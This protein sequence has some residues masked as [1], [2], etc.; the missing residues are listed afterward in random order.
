MFLLSFA[1]DSLEET[2]RDIRDRGGQ[3]LS[4][5]ARKVLEDWVVIDLDPEQFFGAQLQIV[6]Q[7]APT[8]S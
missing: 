6:E 1:V 4:E 2:A 3:L 8:A 5:Q 7:A